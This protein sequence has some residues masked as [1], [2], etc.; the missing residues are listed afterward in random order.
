[1]TRGRACGSL[2]PMTGAAGV[3]LTDIL[4]VAASNLEAARSQM[5]FTLGCTS[6]WC[7][8]AW[9]CRDHA[10][11]NYLGLRRDDAVAMQLARRWSKVMAVRS[12]S[13]R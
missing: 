11:R 3:P 9:R 10:D 8:W 12:R 7:R 4:P 5:A 6:S 2:P 1:M 13:A